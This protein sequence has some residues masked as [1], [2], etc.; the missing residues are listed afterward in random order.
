MYPAP[1]SQWAWWSNL[2]LNVPFVEPDNLSIAV[3]SNLKLLLLF[4]VL[5]LLASRAAA[6]TADAFLR[7]L[8]MVG[9]FYLAIAYVVVYL[10]ELR[11]F[12][13]LAIVVIP[14]AAIEIERMVD[15]QR[16]GRQADHGRPS[17]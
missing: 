11:H 9:V 6:R 5:W 4:N 3:V 12:L 7:S 1:V 13:P 10:R 14:L 17:A 2:A 8:A 15:A 16:R